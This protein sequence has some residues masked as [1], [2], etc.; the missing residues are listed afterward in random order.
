MRLGT[1]VKRER[2]P[3]NTYPPTAAS[4][5]KYIKENHL[6][7]FQIADM[8]Q[9]SRRTVGYWQ[10]GKIQI[11]YSCW[12]TLRT[13]IDGSPPMEQINYE[14]ETWDVVSNSLAIGPMNK[15]L[16]LNSGEPL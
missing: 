1:T 11:P 13:K 9:V 3:V 4:L 2:K 8:L 14:G 7:A 10:A 16:L 5:R 12:F 6:N 15:K